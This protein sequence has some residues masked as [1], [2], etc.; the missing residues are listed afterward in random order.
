V[1]VHDERSDAAPDH[2]AKSRRC[3]IVRTFVPMNRSNE[4]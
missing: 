1:V 4:I 2:P 3:E